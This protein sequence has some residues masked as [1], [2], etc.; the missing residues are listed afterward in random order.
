MLNLPTYLCF[1]DNGG[2]AENP[3][4]LSTLGL[5]CAKE[6]EILGIGVPGNLPQFCIDNLKLK[7]LTGVQNLSYATSPPTTRLWENNTVTT[8]GGGYVFIL[9]YTFS[10]SPKPFLLSLQPHHFKQL[11]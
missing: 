1:F 7:G 11:C 2:S 9:S 5:K 8:G 4:S 3:L 10:F 6:F